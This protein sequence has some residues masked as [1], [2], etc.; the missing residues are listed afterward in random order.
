MCV[1]QYFPCDKSQIYVA[2]RV[3]GLAL[4]AITR[5]LKRGRQREITHTEEKTTSPRKWRLEWCC[6]EPRNA[7]SPKKE[8][9]ARN[10]LP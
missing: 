7:G 10:S 6:H 5:V 8:E 9:E 1:A 3:S 4:N 2:V